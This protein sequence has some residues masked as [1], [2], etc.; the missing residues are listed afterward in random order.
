[1]CLVNINLCGRTVIWH[2][3]TKRLWQEHHKSTGVRMGKDRLN[4]VMVHVF[5]RNIFQNIRKNHILRRIGRRFRINHSR[6]LFF[7]LKW[8]NKPFPNY[9]F[10]YNWIQLHSRQV[11]K[12]G[13]TQGEKREKRHV[14]WWRVR[15]LDDDDDNFWDE[16]GECQYLVPKGVRRE[17]R[18]RQYF[19]THP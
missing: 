2:D 18:S 1:M 9:Y 6:K 17:G 14:A 12:R 11:F 7:S 3:K 19:W 15:K 4:S 8:L 5:G 16:L 13:G 10:S